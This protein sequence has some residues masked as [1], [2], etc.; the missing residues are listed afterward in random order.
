MK[1][2]KVSLPDDV[3]AVIEKASAEAGHSLSEEIRRR[4]EQTLKENAY[5]SETRKLMAAVHRFAVLVKLQTNHRWQDHPAANRVM[6]QA[7]T[8]R[9]ARL[10]PGGE[11]LFSPDELPS[12]RL[13]T[14]DDPEA[15]GTGLEAIDFYQPPVEEARLR[16]LGE[17]TKGEILARHPELKPNKPKG[18]KS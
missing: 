14:G 9:L 5:D 13:V 6:R 8:A 15:M 11:P 4:L 18:R 2:I 17:K 10:K 12:A 7:I 16:E 3:R 1:Q